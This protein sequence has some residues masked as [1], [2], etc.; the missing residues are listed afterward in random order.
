MESTFVSLS[1]ENPNLIFTNWNIEYFLYFLYIC[2]SQPSNLNLHFKS[3]NAEHVALLFYIL[4]FCLIFSAQTLTCILHWNSQWTWTFV[5]ICCISNICIQYVSDVQTLVFCRGLCISYKELI[6]IAHS[7]LLFQIVSQK[8]IVRNLSDIFFI[9][10][11]YV[12][13]FRYWRM[14]F[15]SLPHKCHV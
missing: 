10:K 13:F 14:R 15:L 2:G 3:L 5:C 6:S 4:I 11:I 8:Q 9:N 12:K 7:S 1:R